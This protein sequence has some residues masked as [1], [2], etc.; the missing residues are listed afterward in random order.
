MTAAPWRPLTVEPGVVETA[1]R[2]AVRHAILPLAATG[3]PPADV[4]G[5]TR[6]ILEDG[7][8]LQLLVTVQPAGGGDLNGRAVVRYHV[9][10]Q[11]R[12][13][14]TA[15]LIEGEAALDRATRAFLELTVRL[16]GATGR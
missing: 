5:I 1:V 9:G 12:V 3:E 4:D 7:R 15:F 10:G 2:A 8:E 14:T 13:H 6:R 16:S 11:G